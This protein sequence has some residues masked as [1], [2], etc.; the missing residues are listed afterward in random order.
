MEII[1]WLFYQAVR[2]VI[3]Y[4][5]YKVFKDVVPADAKSPF[6]AYGNVVVVAA[7]L[8]FLQWHRYGTHREDMDPVHGGGTVVVDFEPTSKER[9]QRG[10]FIFSIIATVG[11]VGVYRGLQ[12]RK[13]CE[14][15]LESQD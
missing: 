2:L 11:S 4:G 12:K 1:L 3:L 9:D 8:A 5:I 10:F 13:V 6:K 7:I 14:K 15:Q